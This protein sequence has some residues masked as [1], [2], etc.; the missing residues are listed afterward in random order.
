MD[1]SK[2]K[3]FAI[4][5]RR[6][7]IKDVTYR[8]GLI[9]ITDKEIKEPVYK[10]NELQMFDIGTNEPYTIKGEEIKQRNNLVIKVK[11][12]GFDQVVEEIAYT[13]FNRIIAIRYMEVNDYLPTKVRV[14][15]SETTG[16][17]EPDMVTVAP[18]IEFDFSDQEKYEIIPNLK[19][20]N[21]LD[22]L[23]KLLFIKQCNELNKVLPEL[24]E[25]T[26]DYTELLLDV[27]FTS[28]DSV[29]RKLVSEID[30]S[31]FTEQVEIIGWMYQ[32]YNTDP[33]AKVDA[34][35]GKKKVPKEDIPA[36]TQL[37]TPDWV[38]RYMVE[39]SLGRLWYEGHQNDS[40]KSEWKYYLDEAEQEPEVLKKLQ[41]I[42]SEYKSINP[43]D[44]KIFD[45][46]M[47]SG[48]IL[49]YA[50]EIMMQIYT[51]CGYSQRDAAGLIIEKNL[52]GTDIDDRA[53]QLAYFAVMMKGRKYDRRILTRG[54]SPNL[55]AIQESNRLSSF[56][57]DAGQI[58]LDDIQISNANY[59]IKTFRDAKEFGSI[60]DVEYNDYEALLKYIKQ[61]ENTGVDD[62]FMSLWLT[63]VLEVIPSLAMQARILSQKYDIVVTN[64]PYFSSSDM[65]PK[66]SDY[67]KKNYSKSKSDLFAVFIEK[68]LK[69]TREKGLCSLITMQAWMFLASYVKLR[70]EL[71]RFNLVNMI[72]LGARAFDEI[73]GEVVQATSFVY[74]KLNSGLYNS[75]FVKLD[76]FKGEDLKRIAFLNT[77][78]DPSI[79]YSAQ[80]ETF[81]K[82]PSKT[83]AYWI[84]KHTLLAFDN[85][86][87]S[88]VSETR[89]G[90]TTGNNDYYL[91]AWYE[92]YSTDIGFSMTRDNAKISGLKWF[93]YNKGGE[94]RKWYGNRLFVVNWHDD[95]YEMQTKKHPTSNRIWAHNFNLEY[96][97][98]KHLT[99]NDITSGTI[100][101]RAF[102]EGFLFDS[103]AGAA[104]VKEELYYYLLGFLN[105]KIVNVLSKLLN[106]TLHFKLND[107]GN[108]PYLFNSKYSSEIENLVCENIRLSKEEWDNFELSWDFVKHPLIK[109]DT[110]ERLYDKWKLDCDQRFELLKDNEEKLNK[111]FIDMYS[112]NNE[113]N[114]DVEDKDVTVSKAD[115][116]R[117]VK[118]LISFAV[119]CIVGRYSLD[120]KGLVY[121]GGKW[122]NSKYTSFIPDMDNCIPITDEEYFED[123]IVGRFVEFVRVVYGKETL[124]EN[125]DFIANALGGKGDTSR[126]VIRN[127]FVK[128]FFK[129]HVKTYQKRPIYWQFDSG[130]ENGFKALVYMHRYNEDTVGTVRTEYLHKIQKVYESEIARMDLINES[131][132]NAT[133]KARALKRKEK[134]TKQLSETMGYDAALSH[135]ALKRVPIDL[136][137]GVKVNYAKFQ[138]IEVSQGEGKKAVKVNLLS[139]I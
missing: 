15:S 95:G 7:L 35:T 65:S 16:K 9:G 28:E 75:I 58:E 96:N 53:Y 46:C 113:F 29:I 103:C 5:A 27:S 115:L 72:H 50:F 68:G 47:G 101:F 59:L 14:L 19:H 21:K 57:K 104:F 30:E 86:S 107:F 24:F 112:L 92:I 63:N 69:F 10:T 33:K 77:R 17:V 117:D 127:Y 91:R 20:E 18:N 54:I 131:S 83:I 102:E 125:L 22:D 100:S 8:A 37:F 23:F 52:Y 64:P 31:D 85:P 49:V 111:I 3:S 136:D 11:E 42:R 78:K 93:P 134:L 13:W 79:M 129:D 32:Y 4:W 70:E 61:L 51:S 81:D 56:E 133:E 130:K 106:P 82:I 97:F 43:E 99:W 66:L 114:S 71:E 80:Q 121:A 40:L 109:K 60:L 89:M 6:E 137:D 135:I 36:K 122:D 67:V 90:L 87:L 126:D 74:R 105:T 12:K 124:E 110:L 88:S 55:C 39:N 138:D 34:Y 132:N 1:K 73:N 45:P 139:K 123:D 62:I 38:V 108:L 48:H 76:E 94:F 116:V 2:L 128:D 44:I 26:N 119:G 120:I 41:A 98:K 84:Q 25:K 118:S